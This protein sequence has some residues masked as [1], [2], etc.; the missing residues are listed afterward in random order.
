[1]TDTQIEL[2]P[3]PILERREIIHQRAAQTLGRRNLASRAFL[4][5]LLLAF[6]LALVPLGS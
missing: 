6:L 2:P 3:D 4:T 1:M 5:M